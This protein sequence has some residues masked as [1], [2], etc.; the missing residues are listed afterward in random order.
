MNPIVDNLVQELSTGN[1]LSAISRYAGGNDIAVKSALGISLPL[2]ISSMAINAS[3]PQRADMVTKILTQAGNSNLMNNLSGFLNN[4]ETAVGS[5][6][7]INLFG[8]HNLTVQNAISQKTGLSPA[9]VEKVMTIATAVTLGSVGK[10]FVQQKLDVMSLSSLLRSQSRIAL[11]SS[12]EAVE[13]A[14][15]L[16]AAQGGHFG[17]IEKMNKWLGR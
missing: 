4:P 2:V 3:R 1:N 5:I 13:I 14:T 16:L 8:P 6:R 7:A 9:G 15:Q 12:P 17:A 11:Q 10:M